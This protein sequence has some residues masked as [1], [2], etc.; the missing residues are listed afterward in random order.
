MTHVTAHAGQQ[1]GL[2]VGVV[3]D[4]TDPEGRGRVRVAYPYLGSA[5]ASAWAPIAAPMAGKDR[6]CWFVPEVGDEALLGFDRGDPEQPYVLGFLWNGV[7]DPPSTATNERVI[8]S[9][10]KHTIRFLDPTVE[11]GNDGGIVIEDAS[12]SS[13]VLSNGKIRIRAVGQL[14]IDAASI[15]LVQ[16]GNRRVV[17]PNSNP[18]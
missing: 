7:D 18:I 4:T 1:P 5:T 16:N 15:S 11:N 10:N 2:A 8:R 6:G 9:V 14:E 12:G 13:I 3:V 17:T